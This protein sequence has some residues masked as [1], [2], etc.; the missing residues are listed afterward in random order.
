MKGGWEAM[1]LSALVPL[2]AAS[3]KSV[4]GSAKNISEGM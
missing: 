2:G 3:E 1:K 4:K